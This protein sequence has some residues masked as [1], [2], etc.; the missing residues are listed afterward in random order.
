MRYGEGILGGAEAHC[1]AVVERLAARGHDVR[2]LTT[3]ASSYKSWR[4]AL[5]EG[6]DRVGGVRVTRFP[7]VTPRL[8]PLDEVLKWTTTAMKEGSKGLARLAA[9]DRWSS[10]RKS[11]QG[12]MERA[13]IKAQGPV[14]PKLIE[15]LPNVD[16]DVIVFF[17][18]LYYP[19]I[20]GIPKV[21]ARAV[22]A[23]LADEEP[24]LYAPIVRD[25]L[26]APRALIMN[27]D[28]EADRVRA[29]IAPQR[30]PMAVVA[31]GIDPPP[32]PSIYPRPTNNPFI[33]LLGRAGKTRP[34]APVWRALTA[35]RDA[36]TIE[37]DDGLRVDASELWLVT[38]GEVSRHLE[39]LERVVQLGHVDAA[40]RWGL[41][42]DA[43]SMVSSSTTESLSLVLL[44]GWLAG[45]SG[46]VNARCDATDGHVR[47]CDGG[48]SLDFTRPDEAARA[49]LD[50]VRST[51]LRRARA[52]RGK[53][54]VER[55]YAWP[56]VLDAYER[57]AG[58]IAEGGDVA[59]S[60]RS[61]AEGANAWFAD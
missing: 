56:A 13:W 54:Y 61:W 6:E 5:P 26:R 22:L 37:L 36:G 49:L 48:V 14:S 51:T 20:F 40:T 35:M 18:Y 34:M 12:A 42:R 21:S 52:A 23:P 32:P 60:L 43:L 33:L 58:A 2:V 57:V 45:T 1:R 31:L 28:E 3:T 50:A 46:V 53:A 17:G 47:R 55:R 19:S 7:T 27:V 4:N 39:G 30:V 15:A 8:T 41:T 16:A 38:A 9:F 11:L 44:E 59:S 24:M 25:T 10:R 29:I